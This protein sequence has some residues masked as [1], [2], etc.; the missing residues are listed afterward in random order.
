MEGKKFCPLRKRT[1]VYRNDEF[2]SIIS[3]RVEE[4]CYCI[5]DECMMYDSKTMRCRFSNNSEC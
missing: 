1:T 5:E 4:F 2:T 3:D